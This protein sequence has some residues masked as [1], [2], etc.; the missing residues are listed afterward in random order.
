MIPAQR[1]QTLIPPSEVVRTE[2]ARA[3]R[4]RRRLQSLLRIAEQ[5]DA[6]RVFIAA[7]SGREMENVPA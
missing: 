5:V 4:E 6:D 3:T 7:R 1:D 2:L